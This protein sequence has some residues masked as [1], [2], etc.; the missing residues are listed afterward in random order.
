MCLGYLRFKY[1]RFS[2][3]PCIIHVITEYKIGSFVLSSLKSLQVTGRE[4]MFCEKKRLATVQYNLYQQHQNC[5]QY[6]LLLVNGLSNPFSQTKCLLK[7]K[8][9]KN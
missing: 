8:F 9:V 7:L 6:L 5:V 4:S 2:A 1:G 3:A